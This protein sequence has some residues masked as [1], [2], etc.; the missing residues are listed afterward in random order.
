MKGPELVQFRDLRPSHFQQHPCWIAVRSVDYDE[1][2]YDEADEETFR[3]WLQALPV[4]PADGMLLVRAEYRL[5]DG[6]TLSGFVTPQIEDGSVDLGIIQPQM[7][8][9]NER[10][11]SFWDGMYA[12]SADARA[13]LYNEL[14][15]HPESVFPIT[16]GVGSGTTK[17]IAAGKIEGF[18]SR[19]EHGVPA[20]ID[21]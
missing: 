7:F 16:F 20:T 21:H 2:W 4:D 14:G 19:P 8:L 10:L 12:R 13:R 5:A 3:P 6:T 17:G 9:P 18:Y 1:P 11:E 15:K